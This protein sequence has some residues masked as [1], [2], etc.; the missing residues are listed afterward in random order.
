MEQEVLLENISIVLNVLGN[1]EQRE[2]VRQMVK[3]TLLDVQHTDADVS[4]SF[5][6]RTAD[7]TIYNRIDSGN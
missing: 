2:K 1:A 6:V 4:Y 7:G 3:K 5:I